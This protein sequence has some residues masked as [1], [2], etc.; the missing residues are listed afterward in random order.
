M[1]V[2]NNER[3]KLD[4]ER[5]SSGTKRVATSKRHAVQRRKLLHVVLENINAAVAQANLGIRA[6]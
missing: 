4:A 1:S 5:A 6:K 3:F 2:R